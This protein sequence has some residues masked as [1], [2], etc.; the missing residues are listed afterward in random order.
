MATPTFASWSRSADVR[1]LIAGGGTGGHLYPGIALADEV[2]RRGGG[3]VLF[4]G[5]LRGL[6]ARAVPAAGYALETLEVSGLKRMGLLRT[7]RGLFRLPLAVIKSFAILRRF[8]PDIVVGVGGYASG[9]VVLAAALS[10]YPTA[11]QEQNSVPGITNRTLG[12]LVRTVFIAFEDAAPFFPARKIER[13]GN[14]VRQKI[15]AALQGASQGVGQAVDSPQRLSILVV[16]GSQGARAVSDLVMGAVV[17]LSSQHLDFFL[18]HQTGSAD[19]ERI[20]EH[21]RSLGLAS[22]V[23]VKD[24]IDDMAMAYGQADL[25]IAR[26]GALTLAELAIAAKPAIL[27]PLPTAADDH[28]SKNAARFAEAGAAVMFDQRSGDAERLAAT[29]RSLAGDGQRRAQ[30]SQAMQRLAYPR[31][32]QAIVDRLEAMTARRR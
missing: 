2:V 4:V 31:A 27:I 9:P 8:R 26:A 18:V 15:V 1:L 11:I 23:A 25:V 12:R 20:Q 16:G 3:D 13:L 29:I 28:Q 19:R 21:Y 24:F 10:G 17:L 5:T 30:M 22:Q 14:P 6:E 7:L 32:A